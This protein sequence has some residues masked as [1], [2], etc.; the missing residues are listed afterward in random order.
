V[1]WQ[2]KYGYLPFTKEKNIEKQRISDVLCFSKLYL[3]YI[4]VLVH[5]NKPPSTSLHP[6]RARSSQGPMGPANREQVY[7]PSLGPATKGQGYRA[8]LVVIMK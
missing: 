7:N 5:Y 4:G 2:R 8:G 1:Q 3:H 6:G